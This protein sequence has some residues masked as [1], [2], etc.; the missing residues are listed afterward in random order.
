MTIASIS[1]SLWLFHKE[2]HAN[3]DISMKTTIS[4]GGIWY[5]LDLKI[6]KRIDGACNDGPE[7]ERRY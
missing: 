7:Y 1:L 3:G 4:S 5:E 6:E 2:G